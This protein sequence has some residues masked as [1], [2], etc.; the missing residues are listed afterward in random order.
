MAREQPEML[1]ATFDF[2]AASGTCGVVLVDCGL[3]AVERFGTLA[4][5]VPIGRRI[6]QSVPA[7]MDLDAEIEAVRQGGRP[8]LA[9]PNLNLDA[10]TSG[11]RRVNLA[12]YWNGA[13][14]RYLLVFSEAASHDEFEVALNAQIRARNIAEAEIAAKSRQIAKANDELVRAN[15]D[16]DAFAAVVS[17]DLRSP[18]RRLTYFAGEAQSAVAQGDAAAALDHL[19]SVRAQGRRMATML[20]GLLEYA[21]CGRKID[22]AEPVETRDLIEEIVAATNRGE[23]MEIRIRGHWP[24]IVTPVQ[25]LDIVLRNLIDNAIKHHDRAYG[26]VIVTGL[27]GNEPAPWRIEITDDGPGIPLAWQSAIF[28]PFRRMA[29]DETPTD[30]AGIGLAL[31]KR[32]LETIGGQITVHSD[33]EVARGATFCIEWPRILTE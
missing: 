21:R 4:E 9:L 1:R 18:L 14:D 30:G 22:A 7:L 10:G 6:T 2:L 20:S 32:T 27:A 11:S 12:L 33:P 5:V 26:V 25:S 23:L 13:L 19:A 17:H 29:E 31:V 15:A 3:V 24:R 8:R 28:E 16:L